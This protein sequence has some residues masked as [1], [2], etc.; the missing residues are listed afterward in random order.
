VLASPAAG[1]KRCHPKSSSSCLGISEPST[2][3]TPQT[4]QLSSK[5]LSQSLRHQ[6]IGSTILAYWHH[7]ALTI[8]FVLAKISRHQHFP[9][10][11][12]LVVC[13]RYNMDHQENGLTEFSRF[14]AFR[15]V[16]RRSHSLSLEPRTYT[17]CFAPCQGILLL[18]P[19]CSILQ[20]K[21][22]NNTPDGAIAL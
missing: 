21:I 11:L 1:I 18:T 10:P 13:G 4:V 12:S 22:T 8:F 2:K 7:H 14:Q 3:A 5:L 6:H 17:Q 9:F 20:I 15:S 19:A 16:C